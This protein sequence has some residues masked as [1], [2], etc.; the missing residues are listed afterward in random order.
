MSA[1]EHDPYAILGVRF[2]AT[3]LEIAR[4]RRRLAKRYHP[5]LSADPSAAQRMR[6]INEAWRTLSSPGARAAWDTS[7]SPG[8]GMRPVEVAYSRRGGPYPGPRASRDTGR[9][10]G[11]WVAL[12][13]VSLLLIGIMVAGV[14]AAAQRPAGDGAN[15]PGYHGNL[16]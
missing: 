9:G 8:R 11:G 3:L 7:H 12:A 13:A 4:A 15:S 2:N 1:I 14:V 6:A 16:P 10:I 5:D